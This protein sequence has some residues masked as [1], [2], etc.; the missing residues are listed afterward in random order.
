[1]SILS[2]FK[3]KKPIPAPWAKYYSKEEMN[4]QIPNVS[5]YDQ[6]YASYQKYPDYKNII[7]GNGSN[8]LLK[9]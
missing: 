1:M 4:I 7:Y 2:F 3:K 5:L 6:V 9:K 8:S